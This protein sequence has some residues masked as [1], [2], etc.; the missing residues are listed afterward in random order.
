VSVITVVLNDCSGLAAT[1]AS[2][3][4][5][6]Y[7]HLDF[8]VIDGASKDGTVELIRQNAQHI[9]YW[10]SEP[11]NG[12]YDAMNKGKTAARGNFAIFVNAGD[13]FAAPTA[14]SQVF[15]PAPQADTLMFG[16]VLLSYGARQWRVPAT[17]KGGE[18]VLGRYLPH[19]QTVFYPRCFFQTE[20]YDLQYQVMSDV[21]YTCR[22]FCRL[23]RQ[24]RNVDLVKSRLGGFTFKMCGNLKG[25]LQ[26]NKERQALYRKHAPKY[27]RL[28][29]MRLAGLVLLKYCAVKFGGVSTATWLME[30]KLRLRVT[31]SPSYTQNK[32]D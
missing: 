19:H 2:V 17:T 10:V 28:H 11:D 13:T 4:E 24:Y 14:I 7:P 16:N 18:A 25:A 27:C 5:Q 12:L 26:I 29:A 32:R 23:H 21:D 1:I 3:A 8:I 9:D 22:A 31:M 6:D 30:W 20:S 15:S